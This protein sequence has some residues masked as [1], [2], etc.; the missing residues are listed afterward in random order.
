MANYQPAQLDF[1]TTSSPSLLAALWPWA[2]GAALLGL[3]VYLVQ[4]DDDYDYEGEDAEYEAF[5]DEER[6]DPTEDD[7]E[8]IVDEEDDEEAIEPEPS[9]INGK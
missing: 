7:D 6:E 8:D 9:A 5:K 2:A 1:G 3:V 4:K